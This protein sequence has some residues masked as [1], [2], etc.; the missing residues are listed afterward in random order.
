MIGGFLLGAILFV[1][2][3]IITIVLWKMKLE[4]PFQDVYGDVAKQ[5]E[6]QADLTNLPVKRL[7]LRTIRSFDRHDSSDNTQPF[8]PQ[9]P[10]PDKA[11][12][13]DAHPV[14]QPSIADAE[15]KK[16]QEA[17]DEK[18]SSRFSAFLP[19]YEDA[20]QTGAHAM[21]RVSGGVR[22]SFFAISEK[23]KQMLSNV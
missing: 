10:L 1:L 19:T 6:Q 20:L 5:M 15:A 9:P 16:A 23:E 11:R 14:I 7:S 18:R 2:I 22:T 4:I 8:K 17:D 12:F 13:D 3:S 21:Q